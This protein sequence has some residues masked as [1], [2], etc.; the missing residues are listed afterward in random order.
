[1]NNIHG[2]FQLGTDHVWRGIS[3]TKHEPEIFDSMQYVSSVGL[4]GGGDYS[5]DYYFK[6]GNDVYTNP[7][8]LVTLLKRIAIDTSLG[9][10]NTCMTSFFRLNF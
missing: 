7:I 8:A 4:Y 5:P 10:K 6:S 2:F 3:F 1:V 9:H